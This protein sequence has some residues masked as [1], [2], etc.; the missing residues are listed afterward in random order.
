M[1]DSGALPVTH[2]NSMRF[3]LDSRESSGY[4]RGDALQHQIGTTLH[5]RDC[6]MHMP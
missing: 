4:R 1:L 3:P 5:G 2:R 6:E